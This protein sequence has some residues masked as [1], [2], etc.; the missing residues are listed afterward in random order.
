VN[1]ASWFLRA[2]W[3]LRPADIDDSPAIFPHGRQTRVHAPEGSV[4]NDA[5]H[6]APFGIVHLGDG[7]FPTKRG[8]VNENIDAPEALECRVGKRVGGL[9]IGDIAEDA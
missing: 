4:E 2:I 3:R 5:H 7:C 9:L 8:I 1:S 6:L